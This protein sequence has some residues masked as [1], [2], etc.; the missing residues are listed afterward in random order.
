[1]TLPSPLANLL[2][3]TFLSRKGYYMKTQQIKFSLL[4]F[5]SLVLSLTLMGCGDGDDGLSTLA[6]STNITPGAECTAGGV[7]VQAGKDTNKNGVLDDAE[8]TS[9]A[10]ICNG[11]SGGSGT[12]GPA[13]PTGPKGPPGEVIFGSE[14]A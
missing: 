1:M 5:V 14:P 9:S 4:A 11:T 3:L 13:G 8:V 12:T 10:T 7:K 6:K 2:K